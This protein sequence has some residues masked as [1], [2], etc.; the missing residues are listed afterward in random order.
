M[1]AEPQRP[2]EATLRQLLL[3]QLSG[4]EAERVEQYVEASPEAANTLAAMSTDDALTSALRGISA[5]EESDSAIRATM[6]HLEQ[7]VGNP[8]DR[9]TTNEGAAESHADPSDADGETEDALTFLA[10]ARGP[11]ELGWLGGYRVLRVLG[12]GGMGMVLEAEDPK[13]GRSVAIK[14]M[15]P[16][17]AGSPK[18]VKRFLQEARSAAKVEHDHIIPIWYIG[19]DNGVPYI[20]MPFLKGESLDARAKREVRLPVADIVRI[21][22]ET[23][24]GLAEA[25]AAGLTHRDIKPANLWLEAP[26]G[27]VKILDFGLARLS[28]QDG[29]LTQSGAIVG[30]PAYMAPEQARGQGVDARSDLFSLGGVLY[31]LATGR[32]AFAGTDTMSVLMS[33]ASDTPADP[34]TLNSE[35]PAHLADLIVRLLQKDPARRPQSAR[36]VIALLTPPT[37]EALPD[38]VE[39]CVDFAFDGDDA[40]QV[41]V[42]MADLSRSPKRQR[43]MGLLSAAAVAL[44]LMIGGGLALYKLVFE[45]KD[46]TLLVEVDDNADIRFKNGKLQ[47]FDD[48]GELQYELEPSAKN[49][50][51]PPGKYL[52]KVTG[53]DGLKVNTP[54]FKLDK[55]GKSKIYVVVDPNWRPA[56]AK[57]E[58]TAPA[59][60]GMALAFDGKS[61]HVVIPTLTHDTTEPV[62]IEAW[63]MFDDPL[64]ERAETVASVGSPVGTMVLQRHQGTVEFG[65]RDDLNFHFRYSAQSFE[66][67]RWTHLAGVW[68]GK[69]AQLFVDGRLRTENSLTKIQRE[70]AQA[71]KQ[72][73]MFGAKLLVPGQ[74][75]HDMFRGRMDA[76]RISKVARY[77]TDFAPARRLET[78]Q[79]TLAVYDFA[80]GTGAVLKDSSGHNHHGKIVGATW[81]KSGD[82]PKNNV[83]TGNNFALAFDGATTWVQLPF[84]DDRDGPWTMEAWVR[85][86]KLNRLATIA[87]TFAP[88]RGLGLSLFEGQLE[89]AVSFADEATWATAKTGRPLNEGQLQHVAAAFDGKMLRVFLNGKPV[90]NAQLIEHHAPSGQQFCLGGWKGK[91]LFTGVISEV[92]FS[93]IARYVDPFVPTPR[94]TPDKDTLALYHCDEGVG[95]TLKDSSSNGHDGKIVGAKWVKRDGG[96]AEAAADVALRF[97]GMTHVEVAG[98][99]R[100]DPGPATL[101]AWVRTDAQERARVIAL[102]SGKALLQLGRAER[103]FFFIDSHAPLPSGNEIPITPGRWTH[104][105]VVSDDKEVRFYTDGVQRV[106][107]GRQAAAVQTEH[108]FRGLWLGAQPGPTG[109]AYHFRG[110]M[111][112]VRVS[113]TARYRDTFIPVPRFTPDADTLALYHCDDG[114]GDDFKDS[115]GHGHHGKILGGKWIKT[116]HGAPDLKP[117]IAEE[118]KAL[119][120]V[121][122]IGGRLHFTVDNKGVTVTPKD[123][124]PHGPCLLDTLNLATVKGLDAASIDKLRNVPPVIT[125]AFLPPTADDDLLAKL[126]TCPGIAQTPSWNLTD[127]LVTDAGLVH[128][129]KYPNLM[130]VVL[131]NTG[132][133]TTGLENLRDLKLRYLQLRHCKNIDNTATRLIGGIATLDRLW[134]DGTGITDDGLGDLAGCKDLSLL[135]LKDCRLTEAVVKKLAAA[136]PKCKIVYDGGTIEPKAGK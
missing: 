80:E 106:R 99:S 60:A 53:A 121:Q 111:K 36:E 107:L 119:E 69:A 38:L 50:T 87:A 85:P 52:V 123:P 133:S 6:G 76:V 79:N 116:D 20:V 97:D 12:F 73:W 56:V 108:P 109:T 10:S 94:F 13:L 91:D 113:R 75:L 28:G 114:H 27:R 124:L 11:G 102:L 1:L 3:G 89:A 59:P 104:V 16:R 135:L 7:L 2:D 83:P 17:V 130:D 65:A 26:R 32:T 128:L 55:G 74:A 98:L 86:G 45:S 92:R 61:A 39:G 46:G 15:R 30:T 23:A 49:R 110:D 29:H 9:T 132:V 8:F 127:T 70:E 54:E 41:D 62:T 118:R 37:I 40:T 78:D 115:S 126:A 136:L 42:S 96:S 58:T 66:R 100:D 81:V 14:V 68:D 47:I 95:D 90:G 105:A 34:R 82:E 77:T 125:Y 51:L 64:E 18:A 67:G 129:K 120:W 88:P 21:G 117:L 31:R 44:V 57:K 84:Q 72:S 101:E 22:C 122:A 93:R 4:P 25:H 43:G 19:E 131:N 63:V 103:G 48:T 134:L 24:E 35:L 71:D 112:E 5:T 33:L